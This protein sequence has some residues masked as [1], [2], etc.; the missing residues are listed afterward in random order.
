M[1]RWLAIWLLL[2]PALASADGR[3]MLGAHEQ[4]AWSSVGRLNFGDGF[5][6]GALVAPDLV[7]TAAHCLY[8]KR[9]GNRVSLDQ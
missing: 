8:D 9:S 4:D 1:M 7:A 3:K 2:A 5:C 6:T